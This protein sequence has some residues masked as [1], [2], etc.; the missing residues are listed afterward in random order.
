MNVFVRTD[1]D[2]CVV[3]VSPCGRNRAGIVIVSVKFGCVLAFA[4]KLRVVTVV[5]VKEL[6]VAV[7]EIVPF[8]TFRPYRQF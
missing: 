6:R 3:F 5:V 8:G 1:H 2:I 4:M 7:P